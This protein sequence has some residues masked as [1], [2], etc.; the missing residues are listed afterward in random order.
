[1]TNQKLD[2]ATIDILIGKIIIDAKDN[3]IKLDNGTTIYIEDSE[4]E[5][6]NN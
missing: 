2:Q 1:M 3:W 5:M 6:L 4:I